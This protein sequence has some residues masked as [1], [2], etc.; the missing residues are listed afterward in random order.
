MRWMMTAALALGL[1]VPASADEK[2]DERGG[3][4]K[5]I[6]E[7]TASGLAEVNLS[8]FAVKLA[9]R[10]EVREF[11]QHMIDDHTKANT[12]LLTLVNRKGLGRAAADGMKPEHQELANRL[13]K[14]K[15]EEFDRVYMKQMVKDHEDAVKLFERQAKDGKDADLKAFADKTLPTLKDHLK[16]ARKAAGDKD[17]GGDKDKHGDKDKGREKDKDKQ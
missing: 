17:K 14:L 12:E 11:A 9:M 16:M 2:K 10:Q 4:E 1:T 5:F 7:A 6:K 13:A 8:R 3:D 15:G